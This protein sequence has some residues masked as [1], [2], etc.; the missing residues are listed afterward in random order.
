VSATLILMAHEGPP[1]R[2]GVAASGVEATS[3]DLELVQ[4]AQA[5]DQQAFG[6]LVDRN[7]RVV[8]RAAYAALNSP[9][10]AEDV[11]QET[12]VTAYRKLS[13]FRGDSSFK[14]WLLAIAWRKAIDRRRSMTRW[15]RVTVS[16]PRTE[17]PAPDPLEQLPSSRRSPEEALAGEEL[18]RLLKRLIAALPRKLRD[19]LLLAGSGEYS[20]DEIGQML[21]MPVGTVKWRVS[22]ARR[23]LKH[24]LAAMGQAYE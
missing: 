9:D 6:Q 15:L 18:Q 5:G 8:Y 16:Q 10:E 7:R 22:E 1:L 12:F 4:R 13:G 21:G 20:Y 3:V 19:V 24:K 11:A 17:E 2:S 23:V 14:T